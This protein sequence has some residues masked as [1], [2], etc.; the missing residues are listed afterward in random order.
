MVIVGSYSNPSPQ[1]R[2][3]LD[4]KYYTA[5]SASTAHVDDIERFFG[6]GSG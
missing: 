4:A 2:S 6:T 3:T 5:D 1:S